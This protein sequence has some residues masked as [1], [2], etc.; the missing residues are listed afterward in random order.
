MNTSG[1]LEKGFRLP[2]RRGTRIALDSNRESPDQD[3]ARSIQRWLDGLPRPW[4][5]D[6]FSGAGGLSLGLQQG[7]F[8]VV[9]SA[10]SDPVAMETHSANIP[11][12][13]W[14]GNLSNPGSFIDQLDQWEIE[15]VDLLAGGPPCQPFSRAGTA[16]IGN[17][18]KSGSRP[19]HDERVDLWQSFFAILDRLTPRAILFENVP[20]FARAQ[21]GA[22]LIALVDELRSR[23]YSVHVQELKAW[24]YGVPQHRSRLFVVGVAAGLSFCWPKPVERRPTVWE[25]IGDLPTIPPDT[26]EEVQRY[27]GQPT[28]TLAEALREGLQ[29]AEAGLIRDHITRAV[30]PDDA[31][32]YRHMKPGDTYLD[33]PE[34]LRRYRSDIFGDKYFRLSFEEVS[35]TITAHIAKDGYWYIHPQQ[36]RTL[37]VREAA[38]IQTFPDS[39]QFAGHPTSRFRQIG[40][41]VPPILASAI[42]AEARSSLKGGST[43]NEIGERRADYGSTFRSDLIGWFRAY[44]RKFPWRDVNLSPWQHLLVEMCLHR[45]KADQVAQVIREVTT[46]GETPDSFLANATTLEPYLSTLGLNWRSANL[47]AASEHV[48]SKLNGQVPEGWPELIAIPGVGDYI[49]SA[50]QCF[51]FG[52]PSVLMDTNTIRIARRV[53][54]EGSNIPLWSLRLHLRELAG[55]E[56]SDAL[57][58]QALLDLGALVCRSRFPS[59]GECPVRIHCATG[60]RSGAESGE[61]KSKVKR[62][63]RIEGK[64]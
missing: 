61:V 24:C 45:T 44:G 8:S 48:L 23:G 39:F 64:D 33:V 37:S 60:R 59:C 62:A 12:L 1:Q 20:D 56:G 41:A 5:I 49:A 15:G 29:G 54:G 3:D 42:A 28:S 57:W 58:N 2:T 18:V 4:A 53:L 38:R 63:L 35:R 25:A 34:H 11:G 30:R 31:A 36:D 26:R 47:T 17:L 19:A 7:G 10:D 16:K 52:R 9:A 22:L 51:A 43:P 46:L 21:G 6:L 50:V 40:N 13:T 14:V 27:E 55:E 32:I